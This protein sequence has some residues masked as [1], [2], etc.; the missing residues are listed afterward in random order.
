[1]GAC[2]GLLHNVSESIG[3]VVSAG[4]SQ[5]GREWLPSGFTSVS[6]HSFGSIMGIHLL[7]GDFRLSGICERINGFGLSTCSLVTC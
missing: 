2:L 5:E 6:S 1:M 3:C 4:R 7:G